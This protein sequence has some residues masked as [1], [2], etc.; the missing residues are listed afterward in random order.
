MRRIFIQIAKI[1]ISGALI[2]FLLNRIGIER[3]LHTL[4]QVQPFWFFAA[5]ILF[6]LSHVLGSLQWW[7]MLRAESV[8][9]P[10]RKT[11]SM[12]FTG[13]FFNNFL[14][15][16]VGGDFYRM[17]D[18]RRLSRNGAASV[19]TVF[20]DRVMGLLVLSSMALFASPY[21]LLQKKLDP[22]FRTLYLGLLGAWIFILCFFFIRRFARLFFWLIKKMIPESL[23]LKA[24]DVYNNIYYFGRRRHLFIEVLLISLCV[25]SARIMMHFLLGKSL[26]C[27]VSPV[28]FFLFVPVIAILASL[29]VSLGGIG[30]REQSGV[31]LFG[32]AGMA[33]MDAFTMEF[34]AFIVAVASSL[35]GGILFISRKGGDRK[36]D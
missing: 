9:L 25:Q 35:P 19:S 20:M 28:Y 14:I 31:L 3:V 34:L 30:I 15:G 17:L 7:H 4:K 10:F 23:H 5:L 22:I 32:T 36:T 11:L 18:V 26:G 13:L 8:N 12:Y 27:T 6:M 1:V 24:K 16:G 21:L 29:P 2:I 33:A